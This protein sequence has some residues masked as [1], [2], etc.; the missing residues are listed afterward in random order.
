[1][2]LADVDLE[3]VARC[4]GGDAAAFEALFGAIGS[5]LHRFLL[6]LLRN[7]DDADDVYQEVLIR[8]HRH[9][10]HLKELAKFP[11]WI[12]R[13]AVNQCH[14]HRSRAARRP[15]ASW[16]DLEEPPEVEATVWEPGGAETPRQAAL[17][18]EMGQEI[19]RAI[20]ALPPRQRTC[21]MLFELEGESIKEI[22]ASLKCSEGAVKF[23]LHQARHKL[24]ESLK[25]YLKEGHSPALAELAAEERA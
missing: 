14:T 9:L 16:D 22:A 21:L 23:N 10:G 15:L 2:G 25:M 13:I 6:S 7:Q 24:Q 20:A 3:L 12:K 18:Q 17:R 11:G 4:Q 8:V 19:N 5:D 1:M